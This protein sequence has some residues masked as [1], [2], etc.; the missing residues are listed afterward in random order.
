MYAGGLVRACSYGTVDLLVECSAEPFESFG[1]EVVRC[2]VFVDECE[3]LREVV[4]ME[5][6]AREV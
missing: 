2:R 3:S 4:A 1:D 6:S 5:A